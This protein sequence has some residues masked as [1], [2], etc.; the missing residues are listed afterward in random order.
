METNNYP[1]Q[2]LRIILE[3]KYILYFIGLLCMFY[4]KDVS[5]RSG[6]SKAH[7]NTGEKKNVVDTEKK[8]DYIERIYFSGKNKDELNTMILLTIQ[9]LEEQPT[10]KSVAK[11]YVFLSGIKD[12]ANSAA[13]SC[14][15]EEM[16][17][18]GIYG[19]D[20]SEALQQNIPKPGSEATVKTSDALNSV[21]NLS[22]SANNLNSSIFTLRGGYYNSY[23]SYSTFS[24][25]AGTTYKV[26]G[27]MQTVGS[28]KQ[29]A[30]QV[31]N[32]LKVLGLHKD[33]PC[34]SVVPKAIVIGTHAV[35]DTSK[36][37]PKTDAF[38]SKIVVKNISY[39]QLSSVASA[40]QKINGVTSVNSDDFSNNTATLLVIDNMKIKELIDKILQCKSGFNFNVES[41]SANA[42]TLSV[43]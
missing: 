43:K 30:D 13:N 27:V 39:G 7:I 32:T 34:K 41:I 9:A 19:I 21:S 15:V 20:A 1:P 18:A 24:K 14:D 42:A 16:L 11:Q 28:G 5:G 22:N 35:P 10:T 12:K 3:P 29:V 17:A 25:V 38:A 31:N 33:K 36:A 6:F 37:I 40:I 23:S 26:N 2:N 8:V 4:C